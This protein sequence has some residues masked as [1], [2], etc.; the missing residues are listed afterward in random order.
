MIRLEGIE[1]ALTLSQDSTENN[2]RTACLSRKRD[3][4]AALH[5]TRDFLVEAKIISPVFFIE[6]SYGVRT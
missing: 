4:P 3:P 6:K 2:T 1:A 5:C